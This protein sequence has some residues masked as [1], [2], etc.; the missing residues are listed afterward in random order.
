MYCEVL[1]FGKAY[2]SKKEIGKAYYII[3]C[4]FGAGVLLHIYRCLINSF[5]WLFCF[6]HSRRWP[7]KCVLN[8]YPHYACFDLYI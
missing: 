3:K 8:T 7:Q 5:L 6:S 1:F 4:A 2:I